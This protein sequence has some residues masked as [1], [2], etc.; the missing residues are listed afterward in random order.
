MG[1]SFPFKRLLLLLYLLF[2][3]VV[4]AVKRVAWVEVT[5]DTIPTY[6]SKDFAVSFHHEIAFS[7]SYFTVMLRSIKRKPR[8]VRRLRSGCVQA[9]VIYSDKPLLLG[10]SALHLVPAARSDVLSVHGTPAA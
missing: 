7:F 3:V 1:S 6:L 5:N 4:V 2:F 10:S 8:E 9:A